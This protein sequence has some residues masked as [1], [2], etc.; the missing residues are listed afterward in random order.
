MYITKKQLGFSELVPALVI[1]VLVVTVI[2]G[3]SV[4][5]YKN[6]QIAKLNNQLISCSQNTQALE[7]ALDTQNKEVEQYKM[8]VEQLEAVK[9]ALSKSL[10]Q[11]R[12]VLVQTVTKIIKQPVPKDCKASIDHLRQIP[13]EYKEW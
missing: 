13:D 4:L 8:D 10:L 11:K 2:I 9:E 1:A 7:S 5:K 3:Y 12:K 6:E